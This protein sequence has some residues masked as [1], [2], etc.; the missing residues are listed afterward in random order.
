[1]HSD[2]T[3]PARRERMKVF[4]QTLLHLAAKLFAKAFGEEYSMGGR[5]FARVLAGDAFPSS[6]LPADFSVSVIF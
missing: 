1:M 2:T 5:T 6:E 3:C 4:V